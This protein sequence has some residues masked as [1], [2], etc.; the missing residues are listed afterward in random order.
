M[1][2]IKKTKKTQIGHR[3]AATRILN[4]TENILNVSDNIDYGRLRHYSA[5]LTVK[6]EHLKES[7]R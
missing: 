3:G 2:N 4:K 5:E 1:D 7:G 6:G